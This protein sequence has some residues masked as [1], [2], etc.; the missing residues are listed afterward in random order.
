M[1]DR[2][3]I[4]DRLSELVSTKSP[5]GA[6]AAAVD[7]VT[8]WLRESGADVVDRWTH[9]MSDLA[10][11]PEYPGREVERQEVPVVAATAQGLRPGPTVVLTGHVD[12]VDVGDAN[13]WSREPFQATIEED[14]LYGRGACD[15]KAGVV[16][17]LEAFLQF[18]DG[19]RDF[20]GEVRFVAVPGE[21]DGGTGTLAAI[22][23]GWSGDMVLLC[24]PTA[25]DVVV[26]H[27]GALTFTIEI[28]GKAAHGSTPQEGISA[29]DAFLTVY[30]AIRD[31]EQQVNEAET[32]PLMQSIGMPYPTTVGVV[33][34]GDWASNVMA[35]LRAEA[36]VGVAL[37]ETVAAAEQ[38]FTQGILAA[39]VGDPW[40]GEH[41]PRVVRTGA[42]FGSSSI[43]PDDPLVEEVRRSAEAVTGRRPELVAA[44]YG[45]D[46]AL[47][48]RV[49]GARCLVYGPGDVRRAHSA[50]EYVSISQTFESADVLVE[51]VRSLSR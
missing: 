32:H 17:G 50:D 36:R 43:P 15:M 4:V 39:I 12:T 11:D 28:E 37:G 8:R 51:V 14:L 29:L 13:H 34:G 38:R 33:A 24:E 26:A 23:R 46:M 18:A 44:P 21:E 41:P 30:D 31:L 1:T 5:T 9:H 2:D 35:S 16:A 20:A 3:R 45:C 19:N 7:L 40:L 25:G 48:T 6:E 42:A 22:R 10:G 49:G 47:W 27:G